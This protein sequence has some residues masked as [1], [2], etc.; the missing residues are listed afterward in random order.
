MLIRY[1]I[2]DKTFVCADFLKK[3]RVTEKDECGSSN[4][5]AD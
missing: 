2:L 5:N 3:I 4:I 1:D